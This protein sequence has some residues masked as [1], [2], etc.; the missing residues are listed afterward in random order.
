MVTSWSAV[1]ED[2]VVASCRDQGVPVK[3]TDTR[4]MDR[5]RTLLGGEPGDPDRGGSAG[6]APGSP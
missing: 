5:V 6:G 4:A 1:V 3:V 2:W